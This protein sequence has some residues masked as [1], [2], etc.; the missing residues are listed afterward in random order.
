[1]AALDV[2]RAGAR[3]VAGSRDYGARIFD[4]NGMKADLR[5]FRQLVPNEGHPVHALSFSPSGEARACNPSP[6][7]P[8]PCTVPSADALRGLPGARAVYQ[9]LRRVRGGRAGPFPGSV[10]PLVSALWL[11]SL[12]PFRE[13]ELSREGAWAVLTILARLLSSNN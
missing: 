1:V 8:K 9:P 11:W 2:D 7:W 13:A 4:F 3:V 6:T 12:R 5:A 10:C